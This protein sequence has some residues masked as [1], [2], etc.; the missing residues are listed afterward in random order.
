[1][2]LMNSV[3]LLLVFIFSVRRLTLCEDLDHSS[4]GDVLFHGYFQPPSKFLL[5]FL[6]YSL[7]KM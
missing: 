2:I 4:C 1:M 3:I 5:R 7:P 6:V